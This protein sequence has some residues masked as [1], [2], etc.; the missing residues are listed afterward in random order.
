MSGSRG[1]S[2]SEDVLRELKERFVLIIDDN[3]NLSIMTYSQAVEKYKKVIQTKLDRYLRFFT[4]P[5]Y[6]SLFLVRV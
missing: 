6:K 5:I 3:D 4:I 1:N 2:T